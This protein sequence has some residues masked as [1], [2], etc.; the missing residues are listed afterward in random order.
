MCGCVYVCMYVCM[1]VYIY[2]YKYIYMQARHESVTKIFFQH[3]FSISMYMDVFARNARVSKNFFAILILQVYVG[4]YMYV[5][6]CMHARAR[7]E[8]AS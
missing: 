8:Y 6:A 4:I 3:Y 7:N 2:V 5:Y 1:Y